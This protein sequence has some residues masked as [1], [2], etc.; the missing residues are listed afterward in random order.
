MFHKHLRD[1]KLQFSSV[2]MIITLRHRLTIIFL[3][4]DL[5]PALREKAKGIM[6]SPQNMA[7][8][9]GSINQSVRFLPFWH[10]VACASLRF[11]KAS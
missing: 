10:S 1:K 9:P 3:L 2:F 5:D 11:R 4:S 7:L 6:N 8:I